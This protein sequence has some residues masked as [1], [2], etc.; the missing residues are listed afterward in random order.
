MKSGPPDNVITT[1]SVKITGRVQGVGFRAATVRQAELLGITGWVRNTADD[2]VEAT[3]QGALAQISLMISWLRKGP[4][5]ARVDGVASRPETG[6]H[7]F[8]R[9]EQR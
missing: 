2:S 5:A 1:V 7:H 9:F 4:P 3:L 6:A 8:Q